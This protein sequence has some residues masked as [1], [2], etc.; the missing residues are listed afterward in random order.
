MAG[1]ASIRPEAACEKRGMEMERRRLGRLGHR[2]S[3]VMYGGAALSQV[4]QA[5]ADASITQAL[6]QGVNHFDT[7]ASYGDAEVRMGPHMAR[8]RA[9]SADVFLATKTGERSADRAYQEICR[10]LERLRVDRVDLLQLHAVGDLAELDKATGPGRAP[11]AARPQRA[12]A[13]E[14][15]CPPDR[16]SP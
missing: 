16:R 12:P 8:L 5:E 3:V 4:S 2:S 9:E 10:S 7:A 6:A 1:K 11:A 15:G 14:G 13:G